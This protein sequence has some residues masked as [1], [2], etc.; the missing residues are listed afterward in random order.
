MSAINKILVLSVE[1]FSNVRWNCG[2][3]EPRR[4]AHLGEHREEALPGPEDLVAEARDAEPDDGGDV[5]VV[6]RLDEPARRGAG[7]QPSVP[8][9]RT[10]I[11]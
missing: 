8:D 11:L 3:A 1:T 6:Q 5:H 7:R 4:T 9:P 2:H 10:T